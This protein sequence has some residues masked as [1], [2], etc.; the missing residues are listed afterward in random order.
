MWWKNY[1]VKFKCHKAADGTRMV[2]MPQ[3]DK[4]QFEMSFILPTA[5]EKIGDLIM[6]LKSGEYG[7]WL[8]KARKMCVDLRLPRIKLTE[9]VDMIPSFQSLGIQS[10]FSAGPDKWDR[11]VKDNPKVFISAVT[12][13][14]MLQVDEEGAKVAAASRATGG[15]ECLPAMFKVDCNRPF[16]VVLSESTT[17]AIICA[18]VISNPDP[19]IKLDTSEEGQKKI[20][21]REQR[22]R[23]HRREMYMDDSD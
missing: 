9:S 19:S 13:A 11:V 1:D 12:H 6:T 18:G 22:E 16:M 3:G 20:S 4:E 5:T 8:S 21:E 14:V 15:E 7:R 23:E 17:G 10:A 2:T